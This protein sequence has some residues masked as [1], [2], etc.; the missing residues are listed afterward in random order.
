[1][2]AMFEPAELSGRGRPDLVL[3][4]Y[5]MLKC[6]PLQEIE[7]G[8]EECRRAGIQEWCMPRYVL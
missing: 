5:R 2:S 4:G 7:S 6:S 8:I 1:M 3:E